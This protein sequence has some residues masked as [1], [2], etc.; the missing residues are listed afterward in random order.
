M[1]S[2][3]DRTQFIADLTAAAKDQDGRTISRLAIHGEDMGIIDGDTARKITA[4]GGVIYQSTIKDGKFYADMLV[5]LAAA[6]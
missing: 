1:F 6:L 5:T 2:N 3:A 4:L